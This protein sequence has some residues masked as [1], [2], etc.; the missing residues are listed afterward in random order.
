[1]TTKYEPLERHLRGLDRSSDHTLT[2]AK[3]ESILGGAL[4]N[5]ARNHPAWWANQRGPGHSQTHSWMNAGWHS[6]KLD[7]KAGRVTFRPV[8]LPREPKLGNPPAAVVRPLTIDQ[9]KA[10]IAL[11]LGISAEAVDIVIRA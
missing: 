8:D 1:M 10:G 11:K 2:F 3:I 5:S 9:A 7:L 6:G 4:P